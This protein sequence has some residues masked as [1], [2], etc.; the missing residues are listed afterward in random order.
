VTAPQERPAYHGWNLRGDIGVYRSGLM[1]SLTRW[2]PAQHE[3]G[4]VAKLY[5]EWGP[6][7]DLTP[8]EALDRLIARLVAYRADGGMPQR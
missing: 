4:V 7:E 6:A 1:H 3:R 2:T 8:A 5:R